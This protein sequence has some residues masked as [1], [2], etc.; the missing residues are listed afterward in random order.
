MNEK[1]QPPK[2]IIN[3][4]QILATIILAVIFV[5]GAALRLYDLTDQPI[6]FHPTRQLRGAIIARGMYYQL[7]PSADPTR[8]E[9]AVAFQ[10]STGQYEPSILE[11]LLAVSY[12]ALGAEAPWLARVYNTIFW[13]IG[14]LALFDLG[15]R[16]L[17]SESDTTT[18]P[19]ILSSSSIAAFCG[20]AYYVVLPFSVQAS[21]SF[22]PDPGMAVWIILAAWGSF[23][24]LVQPRWKWAIITGGCAGLAVLTKA[25]AFY[26][27]A[28]LLT[29]VVLSAHKKKG[30][31]L[32]GTVRQVIINPQIWIMASF[33]ILPTLVYYAS[34]GGRASEYFSSW[35]L[36]LSHLLLEP[37]TYLRWLNL[38]QELISPLALIAAVLGIITARNH[39]RYILIGLW[40]GYI[41]YGLF[42]PYQ[43]TSHSY[44]H[45]QLVPIT[46]L[47]I[48]P[49]AAVVVEW[50]FSRSKIWRTAA[51][52]SLLA[53]IAFSSWQ[54]LI[55]LYSKDYR[56]EPNYWQEIASYLPQDGK[57]IALTQDYG[58]RLMY[59]GWRKVTLWP[60]RGEIRLSGLRGSDKDF[61]DYFVKRIN[62]KSYFLITAFNQ[63]EDQPALKQ[64]LND[65][66]PILAQGKG[67]LI[68]DL[69]NPKNSWMGQG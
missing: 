45:L 17:S 28:G 5:L 10:S 65:E 39:A 31:S 55:P 30:R 37:L 1:Q 16:F 48:I 42:L 20:L 4:D 57:I 43:M 19:T 12:L 34:R 6:D 27:I 3:R 62:G 52:I 66:F 32:V 69:Q 47:S 7:L 49:C 54:A 23:R 33:T 38:V 63:F 56:S 24:W 22:Q 61:Q 8:R 50:L 36:A 46:A 51:A 14:G 53:I 67:Y 41:A 64:V 21:R 13:L 15:R 68:F 44:Y 35:T 25:V 40:T 60:D 2:K 58:Y 9:Q 18:L 11:G 59:Y 26:P 29:A